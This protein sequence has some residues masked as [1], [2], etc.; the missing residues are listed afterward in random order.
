MLL[1]RIR[2]IAVAVREGK[3]CDLK[4]IQHAIPEGQLFPIIDLDSLP[5]PASSLSKR[6]TATGI[7]LVIRDITSDLAVPTF[8]AAAWD[9][10]VM[11]PVHFHSGLGTHP[12]ARVAM[13]RAITELAQSRLTVFQGVREDIDRI[14]KRDG[15]VD[16]PAHSLWLADGPEKSFESVRTY[17]H[18]DILDD[19]N[20]MLD[21]LHAAGLEQVI[22]V[23]LTRPEVGFPVV[24][25]IVPGLED[26]SARHFDP[27][28]IIV[29]TRAER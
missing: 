18:D 17:R 15:W 9:V 5:E 21:R 1:P 3:P 16:S 27:E 12:D 29:G 6:F 19:V 7:R 26:W 2:T 4:A 25:I 22:A 23:D 10:P 20:F 28:L 14:A 13:T 11:G 8:V 24:K